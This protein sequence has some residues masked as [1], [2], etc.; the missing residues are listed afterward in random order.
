VAAHF[1]KQLSDD[2][3]SAVIEA[4]QVTGRIVVSGQRVTYPE[5]G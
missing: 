2:E 4:L 3:V 5:R 1:L